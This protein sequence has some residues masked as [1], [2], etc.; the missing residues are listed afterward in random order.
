MSDYIIF[1]KFLC[2]YIGDAATQLSKYLLRTLCSDLTNLIL[3]F[4]AEDCGLNLPELEDMNGKVIYNIM[5]KKDQCL[6]IP[7][8]LA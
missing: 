4:I 5:L 1:I 8:H 7:E 3:L 6:S 2:T